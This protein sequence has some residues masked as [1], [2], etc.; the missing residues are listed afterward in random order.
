MVYKN[1]SLTYKET[2]I[3]TAGQGQLIVMLYDAAVKQL[4]TAIELLNL[5]N[6]LKKD[7]ARI[8][9]INK[10]VMKTEE[11]LTELMVS[12]D[13]ENGG[14]ISKN[15]FSLYTWFNRELLE[16]NINKDINRLI[17]VKNM[18]SELRA[19]WNQVASH[20]ETQNREA[21]GLNIAG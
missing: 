21:V 12:L 7:P 2:T 8:E 17:T 3:K 9:Q 6:S 16:A 4:T 5:D 18:L 20:A 13:F 19:T 15:L 14:E 11:I 10:A 1:P